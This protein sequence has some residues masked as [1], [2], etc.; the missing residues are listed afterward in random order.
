MCAIRVPSR[1]KGRPC[2]PLALAGRRVSI[3]DTRRGPTSG[4]SVRAG[5]PSVRHAII[6]VVPCRQRLPDHACPCA[7]LAACR[8]CRVVRHVSSADR[9]QARLGAQ[10]EPIDD[11][12]LAATYP[13]ALHFPVPIETTE[14]RS[15]ARQPIP[16]ATRATP[17][18]HRCAALPSLSARAYGEGV[19]LALSI[20]AQWALLASRL[21]N[22]GAAL[23]EPELSRASSVMPH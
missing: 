4:R 1:R 8:T 23:R 13:K 20:R 22:R 18:T 17:H 5:T 14:R 21:P 19:W 15:L 7:M 11:L 3:C 16:I 9:R 10:A 12:W 2:V 6:F